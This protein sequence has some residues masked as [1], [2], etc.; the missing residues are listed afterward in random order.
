M[1]EDRGNLRGMR[2][3]HQRHRG[4]RSEKIV[5][6]SAAACDL[7]LRKP[8]ERSDK[9]NLFKQAKLTGIF[10]TYVFSIF[11]KALHLCFLF[12]CQPVQYLFL[13]ISSKCIAAFNA[14]AVE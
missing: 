13:E 4:F 3:A 14:H 6:G 5:V 12:L 9:Y 10:G 1:I 7:L 11:A 2:A 8:V